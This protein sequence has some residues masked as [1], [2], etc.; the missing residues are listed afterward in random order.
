MR[1]NERKG[2]PGYVSARERYEKKEIYRSGTRYKCS[3]VKSVETQGFLRGLINVA[4]KFHRSVQGKSFLA[5]SSQLQ[6]N[7]NLTKR[8]K[9]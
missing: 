5:V 8:A 4:G 7:Y 9:E 3:T 2:M 1:A 6:E